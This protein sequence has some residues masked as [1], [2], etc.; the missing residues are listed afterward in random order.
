[1]T[2][3][4]IFYGSPSGVSIRS[5]YV[6]N[7]LQQEALGDKCFP[8]YLEYCLPSKHMK[9]NLSSFQKISPKTAMFLTYRA[10]GRVLKGP[11]R[12]L[13]LLGGGHIGAPGCLVTNI[14][15]NLVMNLVIH[16]IL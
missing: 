15:T 2:K 5:T 14:V 16:L 1:M 7:P 8:T 9:E 11:F 13:L 6:S 12:I 3:Y 10:K 4:H